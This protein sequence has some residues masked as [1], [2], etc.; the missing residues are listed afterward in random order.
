MANVRTRLNDIKNRTKVSDIPEPGKFYIHPSHGIVF[1]NHDAKTVLP[2]INRIKSIT[3]DNIGIMSDGQ[4]INLDPSDSTHR[5]LLLDGLWAYATKHPDKT[6]EI[7]NIYNSLSKDFR[8]KGHSL[9]DE[10]FNNLESA[11]FSEAPT[12]PGSATSSA[13]TS[14][15]TTSVPSENES[16]GSDDQDEMDEVIHKATDK[17]TAPTPDGGMRTD[18]KV[19]SAPETIKFN[20]VYAEA[21]K[22]LQQELGKFGMKKFN[23]FKRIH[24]ANGISGDDQSL[25]NL[26]NYILDK[27]KRNYGI[28]GG[29]EEAFMQRLK[30]LAVF[31]LK[32]RE[33]TK[34]LKDNNMW[35]SGNEFKPDKFDIDDPRSF[36]RMKPSS[37]LSDADSPWETF[38]LITK[39][40]KW[41]KQI[42][43]DPKLLAMDKA[44]KYADS[45]KGRLM[46][47]DIDNDGMDD[48]VIYDRRGYPKAFNG[49]RIK[50]VGD[51]H[52]KELFYSTYGTE[53]ARKAV[54]NYT[55]WRDNIFY[56]KGKYNDFGQ[57]AVTIPKE[58]YN[59]LQKLQES[60]RIKN[61]KKYLP[62]KNASYRNIYL[63]FF[64][65]VWKYVKNQF[66][67]GRR[68]WKC[69]PYAYIK[70]LIY[71][72]IVMGHIWEKVLSASQRRAV[73]AD[74]NHKKNRSPTT[75]LA[76]LKKFLSDNKAKIDP[77]MKDP[78]LIA[79]IYNAINLTCGKVYGL[80]VED[81]K[82][83]TYYDVADYKDS[84]YNYFVEQ[85]QKNK[86]YELDAFYNDLTTTLA[87]R[88]KGILNM[89]NARMISGQTTVADFMAECNNY[90]S[91]YSEKVQGWKPDPLSKDISITTPPAFMG[92]EY[93]DDYGLQDGW[94]V[95]SYEDEWG[96]QYANELF[97]RR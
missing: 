26:V 2:T 49:Y 96:N 82:F 90:N 55:G 87:A 83:N 80:I 44:Q 17:H 54:G 89:E 32:D 15:S 57:R 94:N 78:E 58:S 14:G 4:Y 8:A 24:E 45:I 7:K 46:V 36:G 88:M 21:L 71:T 30:D 10:N 86:K 29:E 53:G 51:K 74:Y 5:S 93:M 61:I 68:L 81:L 37:D 31:A 66:A 35:V 13:F 43:Y 64:N 38:G 47:E 62:S 25:Y 27:V 79:Q 40:W 16:M 77:I 73:I 20:K 60:G 33:K 48:V 9:A 65:D 28:A 41:G 18:A 11:M 67:D 63:K 70:E 56:Q 12:R 1:I 76:S 95:K 50:G 69:L 6:K 39:L 97:S 91:K 84:G 23:E 72:R 3:T 42:I 34:F 52:L 85:G 22:D 92:N 19:D 59:Y 75:L